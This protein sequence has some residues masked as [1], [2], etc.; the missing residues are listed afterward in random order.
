M[1]LEFTIGMFL[2]LSPLPSSL[3]V[4]L[5]ERA[6]EE[7]VGGANVVVVAMTVVLYCVYVCPLPLYI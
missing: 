1:C 6:G 7:V 4:P 3:L 2:H 5:M